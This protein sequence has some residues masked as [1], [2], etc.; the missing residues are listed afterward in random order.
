MT[1]IKSKYI[2]ST[3][4]HTQIKNAFTLKLYIIYD[5][6]MDQKSLVR[7]FKIHVLIKTVKSIQWKEK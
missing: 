3:Q 2:L 4:T 5:E 1:Y 7:N 6:K